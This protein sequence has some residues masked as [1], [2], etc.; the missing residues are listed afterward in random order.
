MSCGSSRQMRLLARSL[1][2]ITSSCATF[3]KSSRLRAWLRAAARAT[4][5][6]AQVG[7][8][9]LE[10]RLAALRATSGPVVVTPWLL[11]WTSLLQAPPPP[12]RKNG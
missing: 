5:L 7:A 1:L 11:F 3:A 10:L 4:A 2:E 6:F 12:L 9:P 8:N